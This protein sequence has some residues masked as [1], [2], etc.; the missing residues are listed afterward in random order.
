VSDSASASGHPGYPPDSIEVDHNN[1]Y[2]N[3]LDSYRADRPFLNTVGLPIGVGIVWP[4][5]NLSTVHHN[6]IFDNWRRGTMLFAVP[7]GLTRGDPE[8]ESTAGECPHNPVV[9]TSCQ[10]KYHHNVMGK[11]PAGFKPSVAVGKFGNPSS[12]DGGV[13][14]GVDFWWDEF[15][16]NE[17]NCW[18]NNVG[19]DGTR[20]SLNTDP[21]LSPTPDV[22]TMATLPE[23]CDPSSP[24]YALGIRAVPNAL[25]EAELAACAAMYDPQDPNNPG[26]P[27]FTPPEEPGT[28]AAV[29]AERQAK[30]SGRRFE[31]SA[32]AEAIRQKFK[33]ATEA[34]GSR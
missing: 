21:P 19:P 6:H 11:A 29:R 26:C 34:A 1:I 13:T 22:N 5:V 4:G 2:S 7:E 31:R 33:A 23:V 30:A 10:D 20:D 17:G 15:P 12:L 28:A 14:N 25:K 27:W 8:D 3:N 32:E 16:G 18:P 9:K 24:T